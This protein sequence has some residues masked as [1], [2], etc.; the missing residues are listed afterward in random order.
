MEKLTEEVRLKRRSLDN[1]MTATLTAQVWLFLFVCHR[2]CKCSGTSALLSTLA[3]SFV[4]IIFVFNLFFSFSL[5]V[6]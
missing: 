4:F 2:L 1:E 6:F 3:L 5:F